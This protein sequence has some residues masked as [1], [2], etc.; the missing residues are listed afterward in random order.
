[1]QGDDKVESNYFIVLH[2]FHDLAFIRCHDK[3]YTFDRGGRLLWIMED[4]KKIERSLNNRFVE[5]RGLGPD[6]V[7]RSN[8]LLD[9]KESERI[10]NRMISDIF[11]ILSVV[12]SNLDCCNKWGI[13]H[14]TI[15]NVIDFLEKI[16]SFDYAKALQEKAW[17]E[18]IYT[19]IEIFPNDL[20]FP[21]IIQL[22][23]GCAYNKCTFCGFYKNKPFRIKNLEELKQHIKKIKIFLG[24]SIKNKSTIF[25]GDANAL[26]IEQDLL[27]Q[28]F[29]IINEE[30][31][32]K[33][34]KK[35]HINA[36]AE[37]KPLTFDGIYFFIDVFY[38]KQ[39]SA[40]DFI[41]LRKKNLKKIYIGMESD[42]NKVLSFIKKC[43]TADQII[44]LVEKIKKAGIAVGIMVIAGLGGDKYYYDHVNDTIEV[45]SALNLDG[46]DI[47]II[48]D[49]LLIY[50]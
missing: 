5:K 22:T 16:V 23:T 21:L 17:F 3:D 10:Y 12:N 28:M 25:L 43:N 49:S 19:P 50:T 45:I 33:D 31:K 30:F 11:E 14:N 2:F 4:D 42:S 35:N 37:N 38:G 1:M 36:N 29:D 40:S 8:T 39:K 47:N 26:M 41:E 20:L 32:I 6:L 18:T 46:D 24:E 27:R 13:Y 44:E 34:A 9:M 15:D 48:G 7:Y